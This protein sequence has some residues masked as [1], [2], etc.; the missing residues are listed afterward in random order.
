MGGSVT[1]TL[2]GPRRI[3]TRQQF[4]ILN[5]ARSTLATTNTI[6]DKKGIG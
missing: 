3:T 5:A 6:A 2:A 1:R 4:D